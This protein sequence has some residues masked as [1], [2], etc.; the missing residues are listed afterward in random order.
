MAEKRSDDM[1]LAP[2]R[3]ATQAPE[4][5]GLIDIAE[6][7]FQNFPGHRAEILGGQL[8]VTPP[9]D[10]PH[11]E[12]LTAIMAPL[13][14]CGLHRDETR[15][16]QAIGIW[17][18]TGDDDYAVP[19]L[20][21]VDA[22]YRDHHAQ[23]NCYDP[24]VFRLVLE[25]TSSNRSD[26]LLK[27]PGAYAHAG[28]P[29]YVIGDRRAREVVVLTDP[30]GDE[31]RSRSLYRPGETFKLPASVGAVVELEVDAVLGPER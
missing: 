7:V 4:T 14:A 30:R 6:L 25:I 13:M 3:P 26:D 17:L 12:S 18:P 23:Y 2:E 5:A 11:G 19:D 8:T 22:D 24:A 1:T 21:V 28:V 27:K 29:V 31:Y 9:A 16:I 15:I 10:G 20:A